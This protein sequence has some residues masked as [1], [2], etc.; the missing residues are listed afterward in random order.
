MTSCSTRVTPSD[1]NIMFTIIYCHLQIFIISN[2]LISSLAKSDVS[3]GRV[4]PPIHPGLAIDRS[5]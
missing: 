1:K 3:F 5:L 4:W 2:S